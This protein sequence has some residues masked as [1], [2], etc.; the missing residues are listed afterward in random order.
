MQNVLKRRKIYSN[1]IKFKKDQTLCQESY[2]FNNEL[3]EMLF[4]IYA[5]PYR[6]V[7]LYY[8]ISLNDRV[9]TYIFVVVFQSLLG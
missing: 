6:P 8:D 4:V 5:Q 1:V 2:M 9:D 3:K 7:M